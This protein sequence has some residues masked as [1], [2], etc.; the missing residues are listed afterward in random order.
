MNGVYE[1]VQLPV[2][3]IRVQQSTGYGQNI[4]HIQDRLFDHFRCVSCVS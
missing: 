3:V 2:T 1:A 4:S